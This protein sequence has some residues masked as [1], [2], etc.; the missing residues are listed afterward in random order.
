MTQL[1]TV[2]QVAKRWQKDESTI[3]RYIKE[4]KLQPCKEVPGNMFREEYLDKL[5]G[6]DL[7]KCTALEVRRIRKENEKLKEE[8]ALLKEEFN[9]I[10]QIIFKHLY[11]EG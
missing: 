4:G 9:K 7:E 2:K 6:M 1:L 10:S 8:N 11:K 5:E 3:K